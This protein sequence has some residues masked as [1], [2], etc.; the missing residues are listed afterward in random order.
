MKRAELLKARVRI[1]NGCVPWLAAMCLIV[2]D[3]LLKIFRCYIQTSKI[4][5]HN[6][7]LNTSL[8]REKNIHKQQQQQQKTTTTTKNDNNN[9]TT[10][11]ATTTTPP[12]TSKTTI[13]TV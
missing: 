6:N 9:R 12:T 10:A 3:A 7:I 8:L 13:R 2:F 1:L 11:N 5:L 4:K